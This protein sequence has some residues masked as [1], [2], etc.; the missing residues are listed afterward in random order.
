MIMTTP[1]KDTT[2][3]DELAKAIYI[4]FMAKDGW[5]TD[6]AYCCGWNECIDT[7]MAEKERRNG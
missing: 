7:Y 4:G 5:D 1:P 2:E 6:T 3:R